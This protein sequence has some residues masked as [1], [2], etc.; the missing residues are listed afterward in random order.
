MNLQE[1][2]GIS[3]L[4]DLWI[5]ERLTGEGTG[6]VVQ[7]TITPY[8]GVAGQVY[9]SPMVQSVKVRQQ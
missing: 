5:G 6:T 7:P 1:I 4:L 3:A 2:E 9:G 8:K